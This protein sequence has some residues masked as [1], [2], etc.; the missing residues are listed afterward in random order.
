M[1]Q[2][3]P[4][5][6]ELIARAVRSKHIET[7]LLKKGAHII[8]QDKGRDEAFAVLADFVARITQQVE[9]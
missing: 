2:A 9:D 3:S 8:F 5:Q 1:K 7:H 6:A 4:E